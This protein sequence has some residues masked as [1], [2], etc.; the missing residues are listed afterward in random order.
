[1][2][3][4]FDAAWAAFFYGA[5]RNA[6]DLCVLRII[7]F[8]GTLVV[9]LARRYEL[10]GEVTPELWQP[11][12]FYRVLHIPPPSPELVPVLARLWHVALFLSALGL[13]T[14]ASTIVAATLSIY[15]FSLQHCWGFVGHSTA[16]PT[17]CTVVFAL[18]RAGDAYSLDA[19]MRRR[20]G[21]PEGRI[22]EHAAEGAYT[23]PVQIMRLG[24]CIV[25]TAAGLTKLRHAGLLWLTTDQMRL[26]FVTHASILPEE[27]MLALTIAKLHWLCRI[28][29]IGTIVAEVGSV[30]C[31]WSRHV[32]MLLVPALLSM[33]IGILFTM[34]IDSFLVFVPVYA[35]WVNWEWVREQL[36]VRWSRWS[37][38]SEENA[39]PSVTAAT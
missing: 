16:L 1:M 9:V 17:L 3:E 6:S 25:F 15:F 5:R 26:I 37:Q 39:P 34:G 27:P 20:R 19:L 4:R 31:L 13:C 24:F 14:R 22:A 12:W 18:S 30:F 33:Q 7:F 21:L 2:T 10:W 28:A 38:G 23:W 32:R 11:V 35:A 36:L 29:A 8:L